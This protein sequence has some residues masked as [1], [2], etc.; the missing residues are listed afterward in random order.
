MLCLE[1]DKLIFLENEKSE[2][3]LAILSFY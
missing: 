1:N 2:K 3:T